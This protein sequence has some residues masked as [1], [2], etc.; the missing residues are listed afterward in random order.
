MP[1][2]KRLSPSPE[3]ID[4]R[5]LTAAL[6]LFVDKGYHKVSIHEV[7]KQADVSIGS[8]YRHF[9]GK[10]GIAEKLYNH[11]LNEIDELIDGV[12]KEVDTPVEQL[13]EIIRQL[14]EHTETHKNIISF[15][16]HSKHTDFLPN[17]PL[18]CDAT[19]FKKIRDITSSAI[20]SG[21]LN[22][23]DT[24]VATSLIFG[25][26]IRLIQLRLDGLIEK[27]LVD[28]IDTLMSGL[29]NGLKTKETES[30]QTASVVNM[31]SSVAQ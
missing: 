1:Y 11:I 20:E 31:N 24:W 21:E 7:Q 12:T 23:T 16:F 8:I 15:V 10:E 3:P 5:I 2:L 28:Y 22:D 6:D 26:A 4:C 19:P 17:E 30:S 9:G 25:G 27:P 18:M 13:E 29:W 14:F